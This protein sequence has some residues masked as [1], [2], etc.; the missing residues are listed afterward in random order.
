MKAFVALDVSLEKPAVGI[1]LAA[2]Q[3]E[4]AVTALSSPPLPSGCGQA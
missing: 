1:M 3:V 2:C 4:D